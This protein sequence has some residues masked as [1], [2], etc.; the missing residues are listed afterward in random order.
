LRRLWIGTQRCHA[1]GWAAHL[2]ALQDPVRS[3]P[4]RA[5]GR[6]GRRLPRARA[7]AAVKG[8]RGHRGAGDV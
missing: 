5:G 7:A 4:S 6:V 2:R 3:R 8:A 1:R